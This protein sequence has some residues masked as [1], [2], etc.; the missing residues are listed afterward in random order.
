MARILKETCNPP[1]GEAEIAALFDEAIRVIRFERELLIN[2]KPKPLTGPTRTIL[3]RA[4]AGFMGESQEFTIPTEFAGREDLDHGWSAWLSRAPEVVE[5]AADH[6]SIG[7]EPALS[8]VGARLAG[9]LAPPQPVVH[10]NGNGSKKQ[11][12]FEL[13]RSHV[14]RVLGDVPADRITID[15]SLRELGANSIDRVEVATCA[16]E[17]LDLQIPRTHLANINNLRALVDVF[18][19]HMNGK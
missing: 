1:Y 9:L 7:R 2:Y 8:T 13:V 11:E 14:M 3:F 16:M 6:F 5:V 19:A 17:E 4:S 18:Y 15:T 10:V 12:L